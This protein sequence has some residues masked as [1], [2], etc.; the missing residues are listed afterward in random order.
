MV[1]FLN[2][3]GWHNA[4]KGRP[5]A[6]IKKED[7][8]SHILYID[9][10]YSVEPGYE[11]Y[12][13]VEVSWKGA[14]AYAKW[15]S[16]ETGET[17]RLPSELEWEYMARAG[18]SARH[19]Y[20]WGDDVGQKNANC[21]GCTGG[22]QDEDQL[23]AVRSYPANVMGIYEIAGNVWE[24]TCSTYTPQLSKLS[25]RCAEYKDDETEIERS[26]RGGSWL[27]EPWN[28]RISNR[29][30]LKDWR[31]DYQTGFRL[32]KESSLELSQK[33]SQESG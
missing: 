24:W 33:S 25:M 11:D 3:V 9:G 18:S 30:S 10:K 28:L 6:Q 32:L 31:Q 19:I 27:S 20:P 7:E 4:R 29:A 21:D 8:D 1:Q 26:L 17:Y 22:W 16:Q 2:A 23:K 14:N 13:V 15:L 5:W 12:P